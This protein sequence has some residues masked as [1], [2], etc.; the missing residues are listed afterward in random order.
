MSDGRHGGC[1]QRGEIR[2]SSTATMVFCR[3][4]EEVRKQKKKETKKQ[5]KHT[6]NTMLKCNVIHVGIFKKFQ[7]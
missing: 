4:F 3:Y 5:A 1:G 6:E 2:Q 7:A